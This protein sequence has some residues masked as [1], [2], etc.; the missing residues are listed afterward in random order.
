MFERIKN[1]LVI[2]F[3]AV[4]GILLLVVSNMK[5]KALK[6]ELKQE[7]AVSKAKSKS[8]KALIEGLEN[9]SRTTADRNHFG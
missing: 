7:K 6:K 9:E 4:I 5:N 3:G 8:T 1:Y 2:G